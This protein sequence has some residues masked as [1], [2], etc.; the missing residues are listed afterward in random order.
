MQSVTPFMLS[1]P[2]AWELQDRFWRSTS[3]TKR[4][5]AY[6][7]LKTPNVNEPF[8]L[9]KLH[10]LGVPASN[11]I[12]PG[13]VYLIGEACRGDEQIDFD[14]RP[15]L[16]LLRM[17]LDPADKYRAT[18]IIDSQLPPSTSLDTQWAIVSR[19]RARRKWRL[20]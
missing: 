7:T 12:V 10:Q 18:I 19:K 6:G 17:G 16:V 11:L 3:A 14:M 9:F 15:L 20:V 5:Q 4:R 8:L 2:S 13:L 1:A